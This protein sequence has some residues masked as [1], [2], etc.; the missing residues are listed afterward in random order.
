MNSYLTWRLAGT[1]IC[2]NLGIQGR[3]AELLLRSSY[4]CVLDSAVSAEGV[5]YAGMSLEVE[6]GFHFL[7]R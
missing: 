5:V 3:G 6:E 4:N 7:R 1:I 2:P